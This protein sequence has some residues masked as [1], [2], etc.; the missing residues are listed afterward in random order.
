MRLTIFLALLM[1]LQPLVAAPQD[2]S[3]FPNAP[4][5]SQTQQIQNQAEQAYEQT[6]YEKAFSIYRNELAPIG[7]KYGQYMVGLMYL[8]GQGVDEDTVAASIWFR[9]AAE[10]GIKEFVQISNQHMNSL[11]AEETALSDQQFI[12]LRKKYGDLALLMKAVK[13]DYEILRTRTGTRLSGDSTM[14]T[15]VDPSDPAAMVSG[16][17]YFGKIEKRMEARLEFIAANTNLEIVDLDNMNMTAIESGVDERLNE[18][19]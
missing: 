7:D 6:D 14:V 13:V 15:I 18:L 12:Q 8:T 5:T 3:S 1:I 17:D 4:L 2:L 19:N 10:R 16:A 11:D 9:L